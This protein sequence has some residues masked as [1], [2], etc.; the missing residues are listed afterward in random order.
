LLLNSDEVLVSESNNKQD[1]VNK[2]YL[3]ALLSFALV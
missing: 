1:V 2:E 3:T